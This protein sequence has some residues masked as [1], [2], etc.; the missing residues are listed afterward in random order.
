MSRRRGYSLMEVMVT[1]GLIAILAALAIPKTRE[2]MDRSRFNGAVRQGAGAL[3]TARGWAISRSNQ[4]GVRAET[5]GLRVV[6]RTAYEIF[7]DPDDDTT[8]NNEV[9]AQ[10][11]D[12]LEVS[13]EGNVH[14]LEAPGT[15]IRFRRDGGT[16]AQTL[17]FVDQ[18]TGLRRAV[19][20]SA[21]GFVALE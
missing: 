2:M 10:R 13:P 6:S 16:T 8:N 9:V 5:A 19:R 4:G 17:S 3:E 11:I 12:L 15:M 21:A 20:V 18:R 14:V 7:V 1:V